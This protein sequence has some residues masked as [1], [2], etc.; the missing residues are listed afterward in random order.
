ML[1]SN[2]SVK[3]GDLYF[4]KY[5][6]SDEIS[7]KVSEIAQNLSHHYQ[8][9]YPLFLVVMNGAFIF[10]ADLVRK[11]DFP[12]SLSFIRIKSYEGTESSGKIDV[13]IPPDA[14]LEGRDIVIIEDIIDTGLTMHAFLKQ[15]DSYKPK[16]V[17]LCSLLVKPE[18]HKYEIVTKYPGFIIPNKFVVGYGLDY[19][20]RGRNFKDILQL[21][22]E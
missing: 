13:F 10:A 15:L 9:K 18:A 21:R 5:I 20:G 6:S 7:N 8:D 3:V 4:K 16:S 14:N 17:E 2:E 1:D 12:I 11:L 19:D 22:D